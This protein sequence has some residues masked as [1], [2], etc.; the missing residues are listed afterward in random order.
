MMNRRKQQLGG[1]F[2][3]I[4]GAGFT[5]WLWYTALYYKYFYVKLSLLAPAFFIVGLGLILFP[6]YKEERTARGEDISRL[7]GIKLLTPRWWAII[8]FA[9]AAGGVNYLLLSNL[10]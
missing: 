3:A 6:G 5:I 9:L 4:A 10:K 1:I 8:V 7:Q 2:M